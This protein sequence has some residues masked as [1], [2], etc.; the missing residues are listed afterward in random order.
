MEPQ[1]TTNKMADPSELEQATPQKSQYNHS[2]RSKGSEK[3]LK[4]PKE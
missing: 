3:R 4:I 2:A 1:T